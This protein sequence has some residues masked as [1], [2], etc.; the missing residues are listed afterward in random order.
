MPRQ[1]KHVARLAG[2]VQELTETESNIGLQLVNRMDDA[3]DTAHELI[4]IP[5]PNMFIKITEISAVQSLVDL[6]LKQ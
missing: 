1:V 5:F 3:C 6:Q 4:A 2:R